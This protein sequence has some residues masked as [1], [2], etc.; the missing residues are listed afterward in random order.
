LS[1]AFHSLPG[2]APPLTIARIS[3]KTSRSAV[4]PQARVSKRDMGFYQVIAEDS[5]VLRL[6][7]C[8]H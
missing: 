4:A 1:G 5:R 7:T 8:N 6:G 3:R 2:R